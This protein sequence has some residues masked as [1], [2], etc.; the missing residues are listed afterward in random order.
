MLWISG[1]WGGSLIHRVSNWEVR[2]LT[3][4]PL[5]TLIIHWWCMPNNDDDDDDDTT[6]VDGRSFGGHRWVLVTSGVINL[7]HHCR[8]SARNSQHKCDRIM[9]FAL[10]LYLQNVLGIILRFSL[11]S[12]WF[13]FSTLVLRSVFCNFVGS[14]SCSYTSLFSFS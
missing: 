13:L 6:V 7:L 5:L 12:F 10:R 11:R 1:A 8:R 2:R 14:F 9:S 4:Q 3:E